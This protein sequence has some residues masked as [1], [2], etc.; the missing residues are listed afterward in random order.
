MVTRP[1][2][3]TRTPPVHLGIIFVAN[4]ELGYLTPPVGLNLFLA[5]QRFERPLL[6]VAGAVLPMLVILGAGERRLIGC[7]SHAHR[8][9]ADDRDAHL[10]HRAERRALRRD[11]GLAS[12]PAA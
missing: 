3:R 10:R 4:L 11:L 7:E 12:A 5:S 9:E 1:L 8:A 2:V 6:E